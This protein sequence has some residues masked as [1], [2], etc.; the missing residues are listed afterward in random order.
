M[1]RS[2]A[3]IMNIIH[4]FRGNLDRL[5]RSEHMTDLISPYTASAARPFRSPYGGRAGL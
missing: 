4:D 2:F 3:I 1:R 5:Y